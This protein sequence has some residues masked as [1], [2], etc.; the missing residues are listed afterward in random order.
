MG[1]GPLHKLVRTGKGL[2]D[3]DL[4]R[5]PSGQPPPAFLGGRESL[6]TSKGV[7]TT[8]D[9]IRRLLRELAK[10]ESMLAQARAVEKDMRWM[11]L[12]Y[13]RESPPPR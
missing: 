3:L 7:D 8:M 10:V 9:N 11:L 1:T 2:R 12:Q 13:P 4:C 5:A 6:F